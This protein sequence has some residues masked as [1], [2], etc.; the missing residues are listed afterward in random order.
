MSNVARECIENAYAGNQL[1]TVNIITLLGSA[2]QD[3]S[4]MSQKLAYRSSKPGYMP[5]LAKFLLGSCKFFLEKTWR[6]LSGK[7]RARACAQG[8]T[9]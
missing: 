2:S 1:G 4:H 3:S 7:E 5:R 8:Q 6:N 9:E